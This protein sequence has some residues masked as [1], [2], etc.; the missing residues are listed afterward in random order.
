MFQINLP[1]AYIHSTFIHRLVSFLFVAF[2]YYFETAGL[3]IRRVGEVS[4]FNYS[5]VAVYVAS[6]Y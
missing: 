3:V 5:Q 1:P 4:N 6:C 2:S